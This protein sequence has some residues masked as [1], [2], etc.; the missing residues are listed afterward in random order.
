MLVIII[1]LFLFVNLEIK[2]QYNAIQPIL[3]PEE[4][5][6]KQSII[7]VYFNVYR[8]NKGN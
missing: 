8:Q 7:F 3:D 2:L 1:F 6:V 5:H 4:R